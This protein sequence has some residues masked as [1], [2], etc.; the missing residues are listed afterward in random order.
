MMFDDSRDFIQ[1]HFYLSPRVDT[2]FWRANKELYLADNI[3]E[4]IAMYRAGMPVN[5]P[6]TDERTYYS[7]FEVEF[8]NNWNNSSYYCILAGLGFLPD[9][10]V[11][12]LT[13]RK[14][15]RKSAEPFFE[16]IK[17]QQ[18]ELTRTLPTNYEYLCQL[19]GK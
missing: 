17:Q 12:I 3:R 7:N 19:H 1:V 15:S 6:M 10:P 14:A 2:P 13:Y 18:G 9:H 8:R 4:K 5:L 11:P 16:Q